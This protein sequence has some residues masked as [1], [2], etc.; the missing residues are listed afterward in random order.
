M[1]IYAI[2]KLFCFLVPLFATLVFAGD[3]APAAASNPFDGAMI[4]INGT[5]PATGGSPTYGLTTML[6]IKGQ[7]LDYTFG[8]LVGTLTIG[9]PSVTQTQPAQ[10]NGKV[11]ANTA[12]VVS[13]TQNAAIL[14][15]S[16]VSHLAITSGACKGTANDDNSVL[17]VTLAGQTC[18]FSYTD[19]YDYKQ[20]GETKGQIVITQQ[21]CQ[22]A[23]TLQP[24]ASA[25]ST[26]PAPQPPPSSAVTAP[27]TVADSSATAPPAITSAQA[28][29]WLA[30]RWTEKSCSSDWVEFA[31]SGSKWTEQETRVQASGHAPTPAVVTVSSTGIV[32]VLLPSAD[33]FQFVLTFKDQNSMASVENFTTGEMKSTPTNRVNYTRCK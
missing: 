6:V 24:Q 10:C 26:P 17:E 18:T 25:N 3:A 21:P 1:S 14:R 32:T 12:F 30:G 15:M 7:T 27:Q 8:G 2:A 22:L 20:G 5:F 9:G 13:A 29:A 33:G 23:Y 11:N 4:N 16:V 28:L 19:N 31:Q